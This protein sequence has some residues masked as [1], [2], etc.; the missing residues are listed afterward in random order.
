MSR[1]LG[2]IAVLCGLLSLVAS[3]L[4]AETALYPGKSSPEDIVATRKF[5]MRSLNADLR[6]IRLKLESGTPIR[7]TSSALSVSAKAQLIPLVFQEKY[8]SVYPVAG[9]NKYFK[10]ASIADFQADAEYLNA[11]ALKLLRIASD[12]DVKKVGQH[13]EKVKSACRSCHQKNRGEL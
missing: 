11:Q 7:A 13:L 8:E 1:R 4:Y 5:T 3:M 6:D 2:I 12:S 10:G 9:S